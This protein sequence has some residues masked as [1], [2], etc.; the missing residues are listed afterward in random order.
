MSKIDTRHTLCLTPPVGGWVRFTFTLAFF[1]TE[2]E[3]VGHRLIRITVCK[4]IDSSVPFYP[5]ASCLKL[6]TYPLPLSPVARALFVALGLG[7]LPYLPF[8][9]VLTATFFT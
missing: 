9:C 7:I 5:H 4:C 1:S 8:V 6:H 3:W 2:G